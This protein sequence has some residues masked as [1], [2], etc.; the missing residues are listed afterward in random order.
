MAVQPSGKQFELAVGGQRATIVQV[1]GGVREYEVDGRPALEPYPADAMC[2]G[3]HGAPLIPWPNRLGDGRYAF[4][5][6]EYQ[7]PLSE[8]D[9]GNAIHGFLLWRPWNAVEQ[10]DDR[11]VMAATLYPLEGYP[12]ALE[13]T[14]AYQLGP[15]G[16][17]VITRA[18]NVGD[19]A[20]PYGHG[21]H[22]YLSPGRGSI[23]ECQLQLAGRTRILTD[24][25]RQLPMG[26]EPVQGTPFDFL[27][28]RQ[29]AATR[30]D[31]A[32]TDLARDG[33][34]RAWTRRWGPDGAC[35]ALWVDETY[36]LVETYT[37]D[38]LA[39]GRARMGLGTEPMTCPPNA[40]STGER[41]VRLEP[42]ESLTSTWG[43]LLT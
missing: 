1:G 22:P 37:G 24:A 11:V 43:V 42:G 21:Q 20:C 31:H 32:F 27:E 33:D 4:D 12:F 10:D 17:T 26:R 38:T 25:E 9:K 5:G 35:V 8:P 13:I 16:L 15:G 7:V 34:G 23:D 6:H 30:I 18:E 19:D 28:P 40:F 39:R 29:L 36:G 41:V 14:V 2:D 3:A